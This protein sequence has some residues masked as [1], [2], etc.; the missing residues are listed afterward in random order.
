MIISGVLNFTVLT[1]DYPLRDTTA[2][3]M[4]TKRKIAAPRRY[5]P[6]HNCKNVTSDG[7]ENEQTTNRK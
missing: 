2:I 3:P 5:I 4:S 7:A 1:V 6:A